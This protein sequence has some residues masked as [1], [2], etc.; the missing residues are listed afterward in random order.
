MFLH[1]IF[2][3][4]FWVGSSN[5]QLGAFLRGA[6][7]IFSCWNSWKLLFAK[8]LMPSPD[9]TAPMMDSILALRRRFGV[10]FALENSFMQSWWMAV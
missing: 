10:I 6:A 9:S 4:F 2:C 5:D 3:A 7:T 1:R 8:M